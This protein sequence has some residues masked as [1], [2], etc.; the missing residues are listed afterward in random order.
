MCVCVVERVVSACVPTCT[1]CEQAGIMISIL[2]VNSPVVGFY[3]T[4]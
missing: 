2:V 3:L 1:D 4:D